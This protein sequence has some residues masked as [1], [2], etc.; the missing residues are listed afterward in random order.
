MKL[1]INLQALSMAILVCFSCQSTSNKQDDKSND[2]KSI[3]YKSDSKTVEELKYSDHCLVYSPSG[4]E[5]SFSYSRPKIY[6]PSSTS[7]DINTFNNYSESA[8]LFHFYL[9]FMQIYQDVYNNHQI[10]ILG[11]PKYLFLAAIENLSKG[12]YHK[13]YDQL[14]EYVEIEKNYVSNPKKYYKID[15]SVEDLDWLYSHTNHYTYTIS[16]Q[17][18][19]IIG[20]LTGYNNDNNNEDAEQIL[21]EFKETIINLDKTP[22]TIDVFENIIFSVNKFLSSINITQNQSIIAPIASFRDFTWE[23][24]NIIEDSLLISQ[25]NIFDDTGYSY[26]LS[27]QLELSLYKKINYAQNLV[28]KLDILEMDND[29]LNELNPYSFCHYLEL[30]QLYN[31]NNYESNHDVVRNKLLSISS[32]WGYDDIISWID[33]IENSIPKQ[34]LFSNL[35]KMI[36]RHEKEGKID[37]VDYYFLY[38]QLFDDEVFYS[39]HAENRRED[40]SL[41]YPDSLKLENIIKFSMYQSDYECDDEESIQCKNIYPR[42]LGYYYDIYEYHSDII[43]HKFKNEIIHIGAK[44]RNPINEGALTLL[45]A[46]DNIIQIYNQ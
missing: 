33:T 19:S 31:S 24:I 15:C 17:L 29:K 35:E 23:T 4:G 46:M 13:A 30:I 26:I 40:S 41:L 16:T 12:Q 10:K 11:N 44:P 32:D 3:S 43:Y 1:N 28:N 6:Y 25:L 27:S 45:Y 21:S 2:S 9:S 5:V 18:I 7:I 14:T 38:N 37:S 39:V 42:I 22:N 20:S 36:A 8:Y 34:Q